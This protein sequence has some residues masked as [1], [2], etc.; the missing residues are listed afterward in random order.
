MRGG[1]VWYVGNDRELLVIPSGAVRQVI[2]LAHNTPT[3]G[4]FGV[5]KTV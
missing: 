5:R 4:H 3:A 2:E 1:L